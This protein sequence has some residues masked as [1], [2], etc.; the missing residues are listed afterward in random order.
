MKKIEA[1]G[2]SLNRAQ[3]KAILGGYGDSAEESEGS[4]CNAYCGSGSGYSCSGK[5]S[6]CEDA[7]NG[8]GSGAGQKKMCF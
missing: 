1:L 2:K 6:S 4:S 5:C 3:Q 7:G 8:A